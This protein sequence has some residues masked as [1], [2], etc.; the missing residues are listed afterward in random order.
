MQA[1]RV[2]CLL[3]P[4]L[5]EISTSFL[6]R[7]L[8]I[9]LAAMVSALPVLRA[10][11]RAEIGHTRLQTLAGA[12]L[13]TGAGAGLAQVEALESG[14]NYAPDTALAE[15]AGKSFTLQSGPSAVSGHATHVARN[16][17]SFGPSL[18]PGD[19][20]VDLYSASDWLGAGFLKYGGDDLPDIESRAVHNHSWI[21]STEEPEINMRLDYAINRDGFICVVGEN[22][23]AS[24][25]LPALMGQ[26][27][28]TIAVGRDDGQHS[29]GFTTIDGTGRVKPDIVAPSAYPENATSWTT[30]MVAGAAGVL[31]GKLAA[32][33]YSVSGADLPRA[34][35]A[36]LLAGATKDTV[37]GWDNTASRP[38]DEVYGAGELN[39]LHSYLALRAGRK[40]ASGSTAYG[41]RGW[42][43]ESV[44]GNSTK[45]WFFTIPPGAPATPFCA[46][47][48]WHRVVSTSVRFFT[49]TWSAS[50][51]NLDLRLH[52]A[53]GFTVGSQIAASASTVDNVELVYQNNLPSGTYALVV[54]NLA[55]TSTPVALAWHSLPAA[56]VA[57]IDAEAREIDGDTALVRITRTGDTTL[58]LFVPLA[59]GGTAVAGSHYQPLPAS[60][61]IAA[62]QGTHDLTI[63]PIGDSLAQ[64]SRTITV[65]VAADFALVRD[66]TQS[67]AV[68][69]QDKPFDA[70]RFGCFSSGELANPAIGGET[71]DPDGDGMVNLIEYAL[72]QEPKTPEATPLEAEDTGGYLTLAAVKNSA[73]T[74]IVWGA[75][76][77]GDLES[78]QGAQV[79]TDNST[80]FVARD[81]VVIGGAAGRFIR[82]QITRP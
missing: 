77:S 61:T 60:V 70:W 67:A 73:A 66:P 74:D 36:L 78:W 2:C 51:P 42:A 27:Y 59:I 55:A 18:L 82:L 48:T 54:R 80:T 44:N 72:G 52:Q 28:H 38:L 50:L 41:I 57:A 53:N 47:L 9:A 17:F 65:G 8:V 32:A 3:P 19:A 20:A 39:L 49:R 69:L 68:T 71:A 40:A 15:F 45:T 11:W 35:K 37:S 7:R 25:T 21:G 10:D 30:P 62:G 23:G 13:P 34:V 5:N 58:P 63:T 81:S 64:G 12:E 6:I 26:A 43:A 31:R 76:V 4:L 1:G 14:A 33:P 16:F 79:L 56:S 46:A 24:T 29:A 75:R 22:N